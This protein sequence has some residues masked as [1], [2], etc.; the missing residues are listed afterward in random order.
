MLER[1]IE[2]WRTLINPKGRYLL[3]YHAEQV[4]NPESRVRLQSGVVSAGRV[5]LPSIIAW[6]N[7]T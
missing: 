6:W 4:P 1:R 3:R 2:P 5:P 7:R